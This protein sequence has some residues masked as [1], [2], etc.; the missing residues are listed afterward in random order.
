MGAAAV[1]RR[2]PGAASTHR[3][4]DNAFNVSAPGSREKSGA[5]RVT[6]LSTEVVTPPARSICRMLG[7]C[8]RSDR[9]PIASSGT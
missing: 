6:K 1:V 8:V 5:M 4:A 7:A 9:L 2:F 3:N